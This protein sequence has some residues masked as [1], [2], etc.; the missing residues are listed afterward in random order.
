MN[1]VLGASRAREEVDFLFRSTLKGVFYHYFE[2]LFLAC[3]T[4]HE[5]KAYFLDRIHISRRRLLDR[6]LAK[7]QGVIL[8]TAH[9]GAVEFLP[10]YL[11]LLGYPIAIVAKF[12]T[13]RLKTKC[14][15]K[16]RTVG[17]RIID[18]NEKSSFFLAL[19]ALKEGRIL[20]T[21]CDEVDCWKASSR[22]TLSLF[23]TTVQVDRTVSILWKRS[24][25]PVL[26][27]HVRRTGEGQY[28]AEIE[29]LFEAADGTSPE[30]LDERILKKLE[31]LV[32]TNPDQWYIWKNFQRMKASGA[33]GIAVEDRK[34]R[35]FPTTPTPVAVFQLS[36]RFS[37]LHG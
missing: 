4:R 36:Q 14:E 25:A 6:F 28:I 7:N 18:A 31:Q 17:A 27:G 21:Q 22:R 29:D 11:A 35:D 16:A 23:G 24:G 30:R 32:Y 33:E 1:E 20:I 34:S 26:F 8:V 10:G 3:T 13:Q 9:F 19:S 15:E 2:K 12:K 37:E 5:W